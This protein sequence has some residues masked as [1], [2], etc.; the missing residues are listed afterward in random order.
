MQSDMIVRDASG[1]LASTGSHW[2]RWK[3]CQ[4]VNRSRDVVAK[5]GEM[6]GSKI[7]FILRN[8]V[9]G[10]TDQFLPIQQS[11]TIRNN[12]LLILLYPSW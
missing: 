8:D 5:E 7:Q 4:Y 2:H 6:N 10:I 12:P 1:G 11:A 3:G 9:I